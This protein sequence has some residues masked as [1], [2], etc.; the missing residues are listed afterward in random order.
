MV[1]RT[2]AR[3]HHAARHL[4]GRG[5]QSIGNSGNN[6]QAICAGERPK[7]YVPLSA[8]LGTDVK[9][10][11]GLGSQPRAKDALRVA[12][13]SRPAADVRG[14]GRYSRCLLAALRETAGQGAQ[15]VETHRP[16][17][18]DVFHSPWMEGAM[19]R[20]PCPMVVTV[21]DVDVLTRPSERLRGGGVHLRLRHLALA[22]ATHVI[23]PTDAMADDAVR[24]LGLERE[25]VIVIPEVPDP[26]ACGTPTSPAW[27]WEDVARATLRVYERAL[28]EPARPF[29]STPRAVSIRPGSAQ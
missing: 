9:A 25:R 21:H 24:K 10:S 2:F 3:G 22:R 4:H 1:D 11:R 5:A 26:A 28:S 13:D 14:V 7:D 6:P 19:L 15:I 27:S 17:R 23:V 12:F 20:S 18:A 29:I 8:R 16:R